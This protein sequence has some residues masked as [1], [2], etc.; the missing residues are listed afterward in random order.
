MPSKVKPRAVPCKYKDHQGYFREWRMLTNIRTGVG[1]Q[2]WYRVIF[3]PGSAPGSRKSKFRITPIEHVQST[4]GVQRD[5]IYLRFGQGTLSQTCKIPLFSAD[6][7]RPP[8]FSTAPSRYLNSERYPCCSNIAD[9]PG[10][11]VWSFPIVRRVRPQMSTVFRSRTF[12][13]R[14]KADRSGK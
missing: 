3:R 9:L 12:R 8:S 6:A 13:P 2:R 10:C 14:R 4:T 1:H 7:V 11:V 5:V